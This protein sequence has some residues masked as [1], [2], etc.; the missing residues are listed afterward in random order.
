MNITLPKRTDNQ[1]PIVLSGKQQ[2]TVVGANGSGKTRFMNQ[3][4]LELGGKAFFISALKAL[5]PIKDRAELSC[6]TI[7]SCYEAVLT[8]AMFVKPAAET[9]FEMLLFMLMS[10]EVADMFDYRLAVLQNEGNSLPGIPATKIDQVVRLW[11]EVFPKNDVEHSR[12]S[13]KFSN[14]FAEGPFNPM[15]LSN[16]EKAVFYYIGASLY[17]PTGSVIFVESPTM[18]L[19]R[20]IT[21]SLW[22]AIEGQRPDCTFVY[23]THDIEFPTS[24]TDNM[25]IWVRGCDIAANAWDYELIRPHERLSEQL[26]I[27]LSGSRKPVLFVEG[28]DSHSLD[29]KLYSLI[30]PEYTVK[31]MGSCNK[32]IETVRSFNDIQSFHHLDSYGIVDRDRRREAEIQYLHNKKIYVPDVAEIENLLM[33][34]EVIKAV[35]RQRGRNDADVFRKVKTNVIRE[36]NKELKQQALQHTR[37]YVKRTIEV[38]V[39][40]RFQNITALEDHLEGLVDDIRPRTVYDQLCRKFNEYVQHDDYRSILRVYNQKSMCGDSNVAQLCGFD[41]KDAY[42]REVFN[43]LKRNNANADAIRKAIKACF[44]MTPPG[45]KPKKKK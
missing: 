11:K 6:G 38:V 43:I 36:F 41:N 2:I 29:Y 16:G 35:A 40:R 30:F 13:I 42:V 37:H 26:I 45:E 12:G 27:D 14:R 9:E 23:L 15:R 17:A 4:M 31:P 24:R 32:V 28:D 20:T 1:P 8:R 18:F 21:Q 7:T 5:F 34:E 25:T 10:D 44:D 3:M 39:D 19:H 22:S 33:L